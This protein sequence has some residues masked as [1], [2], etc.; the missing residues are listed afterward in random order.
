MEQGSRL[1]LERRIS[2]LYGAESAAMKA[3]DIVQEEM[4]AEK[5]FILL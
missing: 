2:L 3:F 5:G 4:C 1:F